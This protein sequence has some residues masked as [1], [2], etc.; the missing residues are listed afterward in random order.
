MEKLQE[1]RNLAGENGYSQIGECRDGSTLWFS[2]EGLNAAAGN[3]KR[4]CIDSVTDSLTIF[5]GSI[6][7]KPNSKTFRTVASLRDWFLTQS[8]VD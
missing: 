6:M 8:G 5:S 4:L 1:F 2:K 7:G 3:Q